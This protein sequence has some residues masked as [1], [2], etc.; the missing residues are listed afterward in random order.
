MTDSLR[1]RTAMAYALLQPCLTCGGE[2]AVVG[3]FFPYAEKAA[4]YGGR[5]GKGRAIAY[6][7]CEACSD[8]DDR[9]EAAEQA[10]L[11]ELGR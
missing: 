6:A 4:R 10:I 3:V 11:R 5:P 7:L 8:A 1:L 2:P 9:T